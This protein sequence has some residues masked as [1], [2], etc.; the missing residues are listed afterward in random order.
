MSEAILRRARFQLKNYDDS[1]VSIDI[2]LKEKGKGFKYFLLDELNR[3]SITIIRKERDFGTE[4][5]DNKRLYCDNVKDANLEFVKICLS[6][7]VQ[8][9]KDIKRDNYE[10]IPMCLYPY[11]ANRTGAFIDF[12]PET[13]SFKFSYFLADNSSHYIPNCFP[14]LEFKHNVDWIEKELGITIDLSLSSSKYKNLLEWR[15]NNNNAILYKH[16]VEEIENTYASY[17]ILKTDIIYTYPNPMD[18][19]HCILY[20]DKYPQYSFADDAEITEEYYS[21]YQKSPKS[22][23]YQHL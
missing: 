1:P 18:L 11:G 15:I 23:T 22:L 9:L 2:M 7:Y 6:Y 14:A 17:H 13:K 12:S 4:T 10:S 3:W 19:L 16:T 8:E 20:L 5:T 21:I